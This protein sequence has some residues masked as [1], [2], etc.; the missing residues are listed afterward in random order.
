MRRCRN[1]ANVLSELVI[2]LGMQPLSNAYVDPKRHDEGEAFYPLRVYRCSACNLVQVP[3]Y[4]QREGV[5]SDVYPYLSSVSSTWREHCAKFAFEAGERLGATAG[6]RVVEIASNDGCLLQAFRERS[7]DVLGIE[8]TRSTADIAISRGIPTTIEFFGE[9]SARRLLEERGLP[10]LV[11]ANNV[12]AHVPDLHDF[13]EGLAVLQRAGAT[14]SVEFPHL[15]PMLEHTEFDTIYQE[16]YSYYSLSSF[17]N[18]AE[19][20]GL[21]VSD[22]ERLSIHG[23]S[24]RVWMGLPERSPAVEE[25]KRE[26]RAA[27]LDSDGIYKRFQQ[28]AFQIKEETLRFLFEARRAGKTVFGYAAAAK[29]NTF[30][31]FCGI[32][33]DLIACVADANPLKQ[34]KYLPGSRIAVVH[35]DAIYREK[36][37]YVII[38]AWNIAA[39][40]AKQLDGIRAWGGQF[41]RAVPE[42]VIS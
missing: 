38:L 37:D 25:L 13:L 11:V 14:I 19:R 26:E 16:H 35:P 8:P 22:V 18:A 40:I 30:L 27:G 12:V 29:G 23:G 20:H 39:E 17:E 2:D 1:C 32:R 34:E 41:V 5:F 4:V 33:E 7:W 28:R 9:E 31:N 3:A 15:L 36:P 10:R 24:L 42:L 6:T 21:V